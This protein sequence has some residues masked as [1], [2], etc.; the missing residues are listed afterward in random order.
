M[1]T[2]I[3]SYKY[4]FNPIKNTPAILWTTAKIAICSA[5]SLREPITFE[6]DDDIPALYQINTLS[7][8]V[9]ITLVP[10]QPVFDFAHYR[11][12]LSDEPT[13]AN[14]MSFI[15]YSNHDT[16][17]VVVCFSWCYRL[18]CGEF[19]FILKTSLCHWTVAKHRK[20][21]KWKSI[22]CPFWNQYFYLL[23]TVKHVQVI[24]LC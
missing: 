22:L 5:I 23:Y 10:S 17:N 24:T 11:C 14:L 7:Q 16:T 8:R 1:Y 6:L 19:S 4:I 3:N 20:T 21:G 12:V 15:Y 18:W 13:N 2:S 9:D